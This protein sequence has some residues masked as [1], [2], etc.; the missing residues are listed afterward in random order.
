MVRHVGRILASIRYT[1][2]EDLR[3]SISSAEAGS[4]GISTAQNQLQV[5]S[6]F[7]SLA[8]IRSAAR[9]L[10][11]YSVERLRSRRVQHRRSSFS[12]SQ[13]RDLERTQ[14]PEALSISKR[15]LEPVTCL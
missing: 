13:G 15:F 1:E 9:K 7:H 10:C 5:T 14:T 4:D 11:N 6:A 8:V 2:T 12:G 3:Q